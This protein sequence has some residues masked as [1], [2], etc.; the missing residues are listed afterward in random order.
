MVHGQQNIKYV[1]CVWLF[2][3]IVVNISFL[4]LM[5]CALH[6]YCEM[7]LLCAFG[8]RKCIYIHGLV[9]E[10]DKYCKAVCAVVFLSLLPYVSF[11]LGVCVVSSCFWQSDK[12]NVAKTITIFI[13]FLLPLSILDSYKTDI[14]SYRFYP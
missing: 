1:Y 5:I 3:H 12:P 8:V 7:G 11:V 13:A 6:L 2:I 14:K 10:W 9:Y 4:K